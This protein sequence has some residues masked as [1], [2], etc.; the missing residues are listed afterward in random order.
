MAT[1]TN[2]AVYV[3]RKKRSIPLR[4]VKID[5]DLVHW[6]GKLADDEGMDKASYLSDL[7]RPL[8]EREWAKYRKRIEEGGE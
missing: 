1:A 2:K 6:I 7:I 8:I 3:G 5:G 4:T